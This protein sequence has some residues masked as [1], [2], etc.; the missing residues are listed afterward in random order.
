MAL[1]AQFHIPFLAETRLESVHLQDMTSI[2]MQGMD[3]QFRPYLA[4]LVLY[5]NEPRIGFIIQKYVD[6]N[7][8]WEYGVLEQL[9]TM[10]LTRDQWIYMNEHS[11]LSQWMD[12]VNVV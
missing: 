5:E 6:R 11:S 3:Y 12:H 2:I 10:V 9:D 4:M 7:D 1:W 8:E